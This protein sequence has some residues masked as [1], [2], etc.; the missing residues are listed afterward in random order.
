M[1]THANR[2]NSHADLQ[3]SHHLLAGR[4]H[5]SGLA[6]CGTADP[7]KVR[8]CG[9]APAVRAAPPVSRACIADAISTLTSLTGDRGDDAARA[10]AAAMIRRLR[11]CG[12][13]TLHGFGSIAIT[14]AGNHA[15]GAAGASE[16]ARTTVVF[17]PD[18]SLLADL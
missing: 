17:E 9:L 8:L 1:S 10:I 6:A 4:P 5:A 16:G 15:E 2:A 3:A 12:T 7:G 18:P 11:A 14:G 13:L